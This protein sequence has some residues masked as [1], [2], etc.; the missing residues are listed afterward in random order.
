M[1]SSVRTRT[2]KPP[3]PR[4]LLA[5]AIEAAWNAGHHALKHTKQLITELLIKTG[6]VV[7]D[8][9]NTGIV[10]QLTAY[11]NDGFLSLGTELNCV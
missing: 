6:T 8:T 1:P 10:F 2:G 4:A 5:V 11:G 3:S 9:I 7:V